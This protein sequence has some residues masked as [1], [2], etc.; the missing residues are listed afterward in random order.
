L[1]ARLLSRAMLDGVTP[2]GAKR[3][4]IALMIV[5][6][7]DT[8]RTACSAVGFATG[9]GAFGWAWR[10]VL[11]V[12]VGRDT[13]CNFVIDSPSVSG[14]HCQIRFFAN[15]FEVTDLRSSNG[16]FVGVERTR[17]QFPTTVF[18]GQ[19]LFLGTM[20]IS[21]TEVAKRMGLQ[22]P[23]DAPD[24]APARPSGSDA[25]TA[26]K[27]GRFSYAGFWKRF[28]ASLLDSLVLL[29]LNAAIPSQ[30]L[31]YDGD[32]SMEE[33]FRILFSPQG[34]QAMVV[35]A[36][37]R[38]LYF[39]VLE[40]SSQQ[41]TFGKMALG[42]KVTDMNGNRIGFAVATGR[43]FGKFISTIICC[44]GYIMAAFTEKK[45]TLHDLMAGTLVLEKR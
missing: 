45:Q 16:T 40:S 32:G 5:S 8:P 14:A 10:C 28:A 44:A 23:T 7:E 3:Q 2:R 35:S 41:G 24:A 34:F 4:L 1:K 12:K 37:L 33:V 30:S 25:A 9:A 22:W 11:L 31:Q 15:R 6:G 39:S 20:E 42:L 43:Y 13:N 29:L 27:L 36:V 17:V 21:P 26:F 18:P 38:W 19:P